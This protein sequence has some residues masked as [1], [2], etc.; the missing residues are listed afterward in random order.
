VRRQVLNR[1]ETQALATS[2]RGVNTTRPAPTEALMSAAAGAARQQNPNTFDRKG[3]WLRFRDEK[4]F[5]DTERA[6]RAWR[7]RAGPLSPDDARA[8]VVWIARRLYCTSLHT[9]SS[10]HLDDLGVKLGSRG[11]RHRSRYVSRGFAPA[12]AS[13][14]AFLSWNQHPEPNGSRRA[15]PLRQFQHSPG[16]AR[17]RMPCGV[18]ICPDSAQRKYGRTRVP[19]ISL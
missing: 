4:R 5:R 18:T 16:Y 13:S 19:E 8:A 2:A 15:T 14:V 6:I 17:Q 11:R 1:G 3:R 10:L 12:R 7:H 9:L